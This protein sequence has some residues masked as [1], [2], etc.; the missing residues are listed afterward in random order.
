MPSVGVN[1]NFFDI[2]GDSLLAIGV[3]MSATNQGLEL[4]PQ[5]LYDHPSV[6]NLAAT[7]A[8]RYAEGGLIAVPSR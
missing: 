5:D 2:G 6:S 7:L 3:A 8:A 1:D 4:T